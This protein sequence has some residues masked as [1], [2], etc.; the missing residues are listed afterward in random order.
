MVDPNSSLDLFSAN[1]IGGALG[2]LLSPMF[3]DTRK[4]V[5]AYSVNSRENIDMTCNF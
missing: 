5:R 4:S 1:P 3:S 2:Q